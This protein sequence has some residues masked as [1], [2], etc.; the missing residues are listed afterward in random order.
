[1]KDNSRTDV[2]ELINN[3]AILIFSV[4]C[5]GVAF[6]D[7]ITKLIIPI[8]ISFALADYVATKAIYKKGITYRD[9]WLISF[10]LSPLVGIIVVNWYKDK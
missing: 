5:L 4:I 8:I 6:P 10:F 1:M 3:Y 7:F 2:K 9:L